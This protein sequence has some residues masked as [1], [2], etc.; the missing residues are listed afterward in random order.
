MGKKIC[1][2]LKKVV[3]NKSLNVREAYEICCEIMDGNGTPAQL[4]AFLTALRMKGETIEELIGFC[5]AMRERMI[6]IDCAI[7]RLIDTCG[8]GGDGMQTFNVS[9]TAAFIAA[10]AGCF[11]AKHGNRSV[12]SHCGSADLFF[13]LN[14][15]PEMENH[16]VRE[17]IEKT[18]IG[19]L[20]A[21]KFH[22]AMKNVAQP[23]KE[24]GIRTIFNLLGPL[25]NPARVAY[26]VIGVCKKGFMEKIAKTLVSLGIRHALVVYGQDGI[27]EIT[28][29]AETCVLEVINQNITSYEI[30]P[31]DFGIK[32]CRIEE[33]KVKDNKDNLDSFLN[34]LKGIPGP[35][36]DIALLNA[37]AAIYIGGRARTIKEGVE[38]ARESV[39][40]GSALNKLDE[41]RRFVDEYTG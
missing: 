27:D 29:T 34:V 39:Y 41:L 36:T 11:V 35:K 32:R 26:Q 16:L 17:C 23:R 28:T 20:Y 13:A 2:A 33:L 22:P 37:G 19:F 3:D 40:S 31:E 8:T 38:L 25:C 10:G 30:A 14:L 12:S 15:R 5:N 6:T 4:G 7:D 21:P 9:T 1:D 18:G 24:I